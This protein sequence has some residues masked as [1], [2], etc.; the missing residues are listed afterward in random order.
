LSQASGGAFDTSGVVA[1]PRSLSR[2]RFAYNT[3]GLQSHRLEEALDLLAEA[4]YA[5]VALTLDHMHLDPLTATPVDVKR[6][7]RALRA[8]GLACA[9]ETGARY[10][11]D[12]RAK[13]RPT[14]IEADALGRARR[15]ALLARSVEI[16][17]E[18]GAQVL[19]FASGPRDP[20]VPGESAFVFLQDAL[21][22][23]SEKAT[24]AHVRLALEPE[25][26]HMPATLE[27]WRRARARVAVG[28]ALDVT[29]LSVE[30]PEPSPAEVVAACADDLAQVHLAD[31]PRGVHDHRPL[32]EGEL[33]LG[34]LLSALVR[35]GF[36][37]LV[38][39]E[40]SRHS[41]AAHELVPRTMQRLRET[42]AEL[43]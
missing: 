18:L 15:L 31:S 16:A 17:G 2:L 11:L 3:N 12:P 37:G 36:G 30:A 22:K 42:V 23:L 20:S 25:P 13:H 28:L 40:L 39:V 7:E 38:S 27:Q 32:G 8:R 4:G 1:P 26:G 19:T 10:L 6:V 21:E 5:G 24:E 35:V 41:H 34:A 14:L 43:G 9:V 33:D 29:H